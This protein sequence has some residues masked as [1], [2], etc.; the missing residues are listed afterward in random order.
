MRVDPAFTVEVDT[1]TLGVHDLTPGASRADVPVVLALHGITANGLAWQALADEARPPP[2]RREHPCPRT[3]P[4][5][6][7]REQRCAG[8]LWHRHTRRRHLRHRVRVRR[9]PRPRRAL[10]GCVRRRLGRSQG[11]WPLSRPRPRRRRPRLPGSRQPGRRRRAHRGHRAGHD[12]AVDGVRL[13]GR[14]PRVLAAPPGGRAAARRA[15]WVVAASIPRPR[16]RRVRGRVALEPASSTPCGPTGATCSP[17]PTP[18]PR[19]TARSSRESTPRCSGRSV[20]CSTNPKGSTTR[21]GCAHSRRRPPC[22]RPLS[23]TRTTIPS[24]SRRPP[25]RASRTPWTVTGDEVTQPEREPGLE[26][27]LG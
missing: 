6:P 23:R 24:S 4:A 17:T 13:A 3:R 21:P 20:A 5:R 16:P 18:S 7:R 27:P 10:D 1:G 11:P 14:P 12:A 8:P 15:G 19:C 25:S 26:R 9:S 22:A 2:R